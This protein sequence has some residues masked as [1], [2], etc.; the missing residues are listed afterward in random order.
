MSQHIATELKA[1]KLYLT[2]RH[3][4][5]YLSDR[6]ATTAFVD[7]TI[8]IDTGVYSN[9][10]RMGF[11]RSGRYFYT[12]RCELCSACIPVRIPV[13]RFRPSRSQ[14]RCTNRFTRH[15]PQVDVRHR[16]LTELNHAEH[17][18]LYARY[19]SERHRDGDMYPPTTEQFQDFIATGHPSTSML[20]FRLEGI[21]IA[22][23]ITDRL[24]DGL[25]AIYTYF[26][27]SRDDSGIGTFAILRQIELTRQLGLDYLYLGYWINSCRKM[28]Y[29]TRFRPLELY[30]QGQWSELS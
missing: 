14:R 11:R 6:I 3:P 18:P 2:E 30:N 4:C 5:S 8:A 12:P 10:S 23:A 25:S 9:L 1:L 15:D 28:T 21:L 26:D 13:A 16:S 22:N 27:P 19:I 24:D 17:Y 7:P 20:E 29:K